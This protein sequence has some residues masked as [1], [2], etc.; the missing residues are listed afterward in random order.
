VT[1][2]SPGADF[3]GAI[4]RYVWDISGTC[5]L[6]VVKWRPG[7]VQETDK[8]IYRYKFNTYFSARAA[9]KAVYWFRIFC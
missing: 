5:W 3:S 9:K 6:C 8:L 4:T 1:F 2:V 7:F